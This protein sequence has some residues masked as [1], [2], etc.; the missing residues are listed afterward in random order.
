MARRQ[1]H[2]ADQI[3]AILQEHTGV[4]I[5]FWRSVSGSYNGF[6]VESFYDELAHVAKQDP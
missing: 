1:R 5:G 2:S 4:P 6:V 3:R